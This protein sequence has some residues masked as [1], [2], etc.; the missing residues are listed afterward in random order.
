MVDQAQADSP[1]FNE[2]VRAAFFDLQR[3]IELEA[4]ALP[5]L[6]E[7][8]KAVVESLVTGQLMIT[9]VNSDN[10]IKKL[11]AADGQL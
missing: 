5:S 2:L 4:I 6:E 3:S 1:L 8:K 10:D 9:K 11:L 7:I